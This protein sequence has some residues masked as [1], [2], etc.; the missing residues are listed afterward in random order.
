MPSLK[1][2]VTFSHSR[3]MRP[4]TYSGGPF[5][6]FRIR[7]QISEQKNLHNLIVT[8]LSFLVDLQLCWRKK[9]KVRST[10]LLRIL[11]LPTG[12]LGNY[13]FHNTRRFWQGKCC[14]K[15]STIFFF[16]HFFLPL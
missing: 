1:L 5:V 10:P 9:P 13:S 8:A 4:H 14:L 12:F 16:F 6:V 3:Q 11:G 7:A 2:M 15:K